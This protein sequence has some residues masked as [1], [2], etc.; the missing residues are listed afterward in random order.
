M[1][2]V[3]PKVK[4][5]L[6]DLDPTLYVIEPHSDDAFLSCHQHMLN[7]I[8][9][10]FKVHILTIFSNPKRDKEGEAYAKSI[11]ASYSSL[12][13]TEQSHLGLEQVACPPFRDWPIKP[14][15]NDIT[16]FPLGLQHPDHLTV[17]AEFLAV[18]Q[19]KVYYY[20]DTPYQAKQKLAD[21]LNEA[22][23]GMMVVSIL[24]PPATKWNKI[25]I[26]KSQAKF[27]H[28]NPADSL[29]RIPEI[30]VKGL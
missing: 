17:R 7:W 11:G 29:K 16:L 26:F 19:G 27:F 4:E 12:T 1:P 2:K 24:Y 28:F 22:V 20:L 8:K 9:D 10:G 15:P 30:I 18:E 23:F 25:P 6:Q 13:I 21:D 5:Q 3:S 14:G